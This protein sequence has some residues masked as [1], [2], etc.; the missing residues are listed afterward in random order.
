MVRVV[1]APHDLVGAELLHR[2]GFAGR[3]ERRTDPDIAVEVLTRLERQHDVG[4]E[5][6]FADPAVFHLCVVGVHATKF[7]DGPCHALLGHDVLEVGEALEHAAH[8]EVGEVAV[9]EERH[10]HEEDDAGGRVL[11]VVGRA[12]A[13][14]LGDD[15]VEVLHCGPQAVPFG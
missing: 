4:R 10:L 9:G 3:R 13:A 15:E 8:R 14:V 5:A 6:E 7:L 11:A 12:V 1:R 2:L